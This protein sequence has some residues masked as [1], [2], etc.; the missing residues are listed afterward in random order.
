M[1]RLQG[2]GGKAKA[3]GGGRPGTRHSPAAA[4]TAPGSKAAAAKAGED[5]ADEGKDTADAPAAP[6]QGGV[7]PAHGRTAAPPPLPANARGARC[8]TQKYVS[9]D[10]EVVS[11]RDASCGTFAQQGDRAGGGHS[12][13]ARQGHPARLARPPGS[14]P[15]TWR[16]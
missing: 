15:A 7:A 8:G 1:P 10:P 4:A 5:A 6:G 14:G 12:C 9:P 13:A 11:K 2:K 3:A 16:A